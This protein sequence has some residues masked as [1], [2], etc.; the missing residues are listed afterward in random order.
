MR[1]L[2]T[3]LILSFGMMPMGSLAQATDDS[4]MSVA[5]THRAARSVD[6]FN[7][8]LIRQAAIVEGIRL[9]IKE[10]KSSADLRK[11][12]RNAQY[13]PENS[14]GYIAV[15][16]KDGFAK[17]SSSLRAKHMKSSTDKACGFTGSLSTLYEKNQSTEFLFGHAVAPDSF[18]R[19]FKVEAIGEYEDTHIFI[20]VSA[21][22]MLRVV[23]REISLSP[24]EG[25][26][27]YQPGRLAVVGSTYKGGKPPFRVYPFL[28]KDIQKVM[29]AP[30][31][32]FAYSDF[33]R[34]QAEVV[35]V[36]LN[37]RQVYK[38]PTAALRLV[39]EKK[40]PVEKDITQ[41]LIGSWVANPGG[42]AL[43]KV[44]ILQENNRIYLQASGQP[45]NFS[46][47]GRF[48]KEKLVLEPHS[49]SKQITSLLDLSGRFE[50][51]NDAVIL[52][53]K[54][55]D[56]AK[57]LSNSYTLKRITDGRQLG[58]CGIPLDFTAPKEP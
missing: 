44:G 35:Q 22:E 33:C 20:E 29:E 51:A 36:N 17:V 55:V 47:D 26:Y 58:V 1:S 8:I 56:G 3:I 42:A 57:F 19:L 14:V 28:N 48:F 27:L 24:D 9:A 13:E 37:W 12:L 49:S 54:W 38:N 23:E 6:S 30:A 4:D 39:Y 16:D 52:H 25:L 2:L 43:L 46:A 34:E 53:V 41:P 32:N 45:G 21:T 50:E 10:E 7:Q 5:I 31:G 11:L 18:F 40:I 15:I